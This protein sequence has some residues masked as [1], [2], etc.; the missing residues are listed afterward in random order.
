LRLQTACFHNIISV[1]VCI[2]LYQ[3]FSR[4]K[5]TDTKKETLLRIGCPGGSPEKG[6]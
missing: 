6:D 5:L 2:P 4:E 1:S 3:G